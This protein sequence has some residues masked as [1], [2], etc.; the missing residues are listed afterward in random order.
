MAESNKVAPS[1]KALEQALLLAE[2]IL[3]NIEL[4][5]QSLAVCCL[6]AS[7]LARLLNDQD[8]QLAFEYEASGYPKTAKGIAPDVWRI[9]ELAGRVHSHKEKNGTTEDTV[10]K[11]TTIAI[12]VLEERISTTKVA[13]SA[14]RDPNLSVSSANPNQWVGSPTGNTLE[15]AR[16]LQNLTTDVSELASRRGFLHRYVSRRHDELRF[17]GIA[18]DIFS[19]IRITVD[20]R[21]GI[22]VPKAVQKITAVYENLQSDNPEDWANAVHSCR[23]I[24]QD[25]A[26]VLF[27]SRADAVKI[28][29][30]AEKQIRLG[31]DAYINR[32]I[33]YI[34]EHSA[35]SR[36][37]AIVGSSL[38]FIGDRLDATF[39]AA[40][41]GSHAEISSREEADR[42]VVYT[43]MLVADILSLADS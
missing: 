38:R 11:A 29:N 9:A 32:L 20:E 10:E 16:L 42:Y 33:A 15:R 13:L 31:P 12:E 24:L 30:G 22:A 17:S 6:K 28:I 41:K 21:I 4:S 3:R 34:E 1:R 35:S 2:E 40:Q 14:A 8:H 39:S 43:Y 37:E 18:E 26:D 27:P 36:Y 5:E 23:R 7:R 19:R 25:L